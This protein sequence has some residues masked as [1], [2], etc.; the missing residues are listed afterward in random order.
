MLRNLRTLL[1]GTVVVAVVSPCW[2]ADTP[3]PGTP[4]VVNGHTHHE[5]TFDGLPCTIIVPQKAL[6]GKPWIWK[7]EFL[8]CE[9]ATDLRLVDK[10]FFVVYLNT[11]NT[12]GCPDT[13]RRWEKLYELLTTQHGF[14]RR[15]ALEGI[16][17]GG[18]SIYAWAALHPD[19]VTCIYG[20]NPVCDFKSWPGGKG[21]GPGSKNDWKKLQNDYHFAS[22][23]EALSYRGNPVD[24]LAKIAQAKIPVLHVCGDA[25]EVVPYEENTAVLRKRFEQLGGSIQV[26]IKPGLKHHPHGLA[27]NPQPIVD[28][29]LRH[30]AGIEPPAKAPADRAPASLESMLTTVP[31]MQPFL[32]S[33][34][35]LTK[36]VAQFNADDNELYIQF[37]PNAAAL[38]FL[39]QNVPLFDCPDEEF[40]RTYYFRWWTYRKHLR[41]TP[42]GFV[43]TEFLP[44]VSWAKKYNTINCAAG[45]HLYEGRWLVDT[46]YLDDYS[47]FWF[48]GGG[49]PRQYSFWAANAIYQ[50]ALA[51]GDT[52]LAVELLDALVAN[53]EA[54][55][56][57]N[58]DPNGLYW[59]KDV[60]DGMEVSIGGSGYRATINSY[61]FGDAKAIAAIAR[62]AGKPELVARFEQEATRLRKVVQEK[63]WDGEAESFKVGTRTDPIRR[64]DVRELHGYTPWYFYMPETSLSVAWKNLMSP[65]GFFAPFGPCTAEQS[66]P[67]FAI[68]Y[69]GHEC[70]WN[71]PSWPYSTSVTLTAMA[72]LLNRYQQD[73]VNTADY[74]KLLEIYT[75][76]H[77]LK[78]DDG[79]VVAWI[80]ENLNP[81]NGDW[82]SRT[83]LKTMKDGTWDPKKGGVERG[84]DYN[85]STYCDLIVTGLVGLR[86]QIDDAVELNPLIPPGGAWK[87]FCLDRIPYHGRSLTI[88]YDRDGDHYGKGRGLHVYADGR[89][90]AWSPRLT[91]VTA[92]LPARSKP[93]AK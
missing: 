52:R 72:N 14:N 54:W 44:N 40:E 88:L 33:T 21:K 34:E 20:D 87:Y 12:F 66:H 43:V 61:Q 35:K 80:D 76:S 30:A 7:A 73:F 71:G 41:A 63:L 49:S 92:A 64:V 47:R 90:I 27:D 39:E 79:K 57:S 5:F 24:Q 2:S 59:Q 86:P 67:K 17:R 29:L 38:R 4:K 68:S 26:I 1:I 15:P 60:L 23:E 69:A 82:I 84:K 53:F 45:H 10:G 3:L 9:L 77:R 56:K 51:T 70:Q 36:W 93:A 85:H 28:F 58:L 75:K 50:R 13:M 22:E 91:R 42:D 19:R 55:E 18:L 6:P 16:S 81:Q 78:R 31:K 46:R 74:F 83:R 25:D 37:V 11:Q 89:R 32:L 62:I 65:A 8:T 48:V